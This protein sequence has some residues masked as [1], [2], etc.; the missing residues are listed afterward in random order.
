MNDDLIL[1][2]LFGDNHV[3]SYSIPCSIVHRVLGYKKIEYDNNFVT[4]PKDDINFHDSIERLPI[5]KTGNHF[6]DNIYTIIKFLERNEQENKIF[7]LD[8]EKYTQSQILTSWALNTLRAIFLNFSYKNE[9]N[10]K[11]LHGRVVEIYNST[12]HVETVER[13]KRE[14]TSHYEF[15]FI[16]TFTDKEIHTYYGDQIRNIQTYLENHG[17]LIDENIYLADIAVFTVMN[18]L[19][20]PILAE[21]D[22]VRTDFRNVMEWMNRINNATKNKYTKFV[23]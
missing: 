8:P 11:N 18:Q 5:L 12:E 15:S 2:S 23:A 3:D 6:Y 1:Y 17:N 13:L 21:S 20:N 14:M 10:Y 19:I 22:I 9:T 7:P 16:S 4:L